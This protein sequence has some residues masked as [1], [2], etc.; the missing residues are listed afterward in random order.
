MARSEQL[1]HEAEQ[2]RAE[3]AQTLDA[4]RDRISP[5]Q[6]LDQV[7]EYAREGEGAELLGNLR[8]QVVENPLPL[9]LMGIALGWLMLPGVGRKGR[10]GANMDR[11]SAG[12]ESAVDRATGGVGAAANSV[13]QTSADIGAKAGAMKESLSRSAEGISEQL[14][15]GYA[16]AAGVASEAS[17][18]AGESAASVRRGFREARDGFLSAC[19]E[20]PLILAGLG[21]ALGAAVGVALPRTEAE[22]RVLGKTSDE[23]KAKAQETAA[24]QVE[25]AKTTVQ[26]QMQRAK[27]VA[28][29]KADEMRDTIG[30]QLNTQTA[31]APDSAEASESRA[32]GGNA[33]SHEAPSIAPY[34][35]YSET[36]PV[37]SDR[38]VEHERR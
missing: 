2:S 25:T 12:A 17:R 10:V 18:R 34:S 35:P 14:G 23:V 5:G 20:Q 13:R 7:I 37:T 36:G 30:E 15:D 11:M 33:E 1:E 38:E 4:L 24:E 21:L 29:E 31:G 22:D 8:R 16:R 27:E 6:V 28:E 19:R 3:L 32:V 26:Q 9:G